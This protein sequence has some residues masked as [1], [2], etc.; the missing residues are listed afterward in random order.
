MSLL[1]N[2]KIFHDILKKIIPVEIV[3]II[4]TGKQDWE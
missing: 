1:E 2:V 4:K 3:F